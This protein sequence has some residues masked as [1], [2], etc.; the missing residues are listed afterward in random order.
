MNLTEYQ[1]EKAELRRNII[2]QRQ[3]LSEK[4]WRSKSQA[5][6]TNLAN[7]QLFQQ[8]KT[9]L[10]YFSFRQEPDLSDLFSEPSSTDN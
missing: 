9:I 8:A 5:I 3:S 2:K 1:S 7:S 10:A 4:E 6:C